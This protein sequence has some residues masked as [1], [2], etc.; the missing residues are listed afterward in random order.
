ME[1]KELGERLSDL[2]LLKGVYRFK[3]DDLIDFILEGLDKARE[4]VITEV[5]KSGH[6]ERYGKDGNKE[7]LE[8]HEYLCKKYLSKLK[9]NK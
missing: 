8:L 6:S 1:K 9:D 4:E 7:M 5:F 2:K 3:F